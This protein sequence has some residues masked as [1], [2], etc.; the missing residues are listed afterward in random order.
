MKLLLWVRDPVQL[1][2][3]ITNNSLLFLEKEAVSHII[4]VI[5]KLIEHGGITI[6]FSFIKNLVKHAE[7]H[8]YSIERVK[9]F[10]ELKE[11]IFRTCM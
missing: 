3:F 11:L 8:F 7:I 10:Q 6:Y 2:V 5:E 1:Q 9:E 4:S